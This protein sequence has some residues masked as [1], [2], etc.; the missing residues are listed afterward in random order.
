MDRF[1]IPVLFIL[2]T[3]A[4]VVSREPDD[5]QRLPTRDLASPDVAPV[6]R[7]ASPASSSVPH[8]PRL[9]PDHEAAATLQEPTPPNP[10]VERRPLLVSVHDQHGRPWVGADV[11]WDRRRGDGGTPAGPRITDAAGEVEISPSAR[12]GIVDLR[13]AA[14]DAVRPFHRS[15]ALH[16]DRVEVLLERG[17]AVPV[18]VIHAGG[19][20]YDEIAV[21]FLDREGNATRHRRLEIASDGATASVQFE[22]LVAEGLYDIVVTGPDDRTLRRVHDVWVDM[23]GGTDRRLEAID[24]RGEERL[25]EVQIVDDI[26]APVTFRS[27]ALGRGARRTTDRTTTDAAG[28][29]RITTLASRVVFTEVAGAPT[30]TSDTGFARLEWSPPAELEAFG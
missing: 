6:R 3:A 2:V 21:S 10:D 22:F 30:V 20:R 5:Q 24:V 23:F 25:L 13:V 19:V 16:G 26:G 14:A 9:R 1:A 11:R 17:R 12:R 28:R 8:A 29:V 18:R 15:G 27:L 4:F 7:A